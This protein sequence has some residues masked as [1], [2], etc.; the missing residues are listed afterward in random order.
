MSSTSIADPTESVGT[1]QLWVIDIYGFLLA[2]FLITMGHLGDRIGRR[3]LLLIG[4]AAFGLTSVAAA[5]STTA[6]SLIARRALMGVAAATLMPST[7]ALISNMFTD[8]RQR[9]W[10]IAGWATSQCAGAAFGPVV[11]GLLL[12]HFGWGSVFPLN[13]PIMAGLLVAGPLLRPE[14]RNPNP[15]R[16]DPTSVALS[17]VAVLLFVYG[18]KQVGTV[19][20]SGPAA[21]GIAAGAGG[22]IVFVRRQLARPSPGRSRATIQRW[23]RPRVPRTRKP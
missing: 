23:S 15:G 19:D 10:A 21:A 5:Y 4:G 22:G 18:L 20:F 13:V 11:T 7:L 17:L 6:G 8:D 3:R 14:F 12:E 9:G 2:G 16:L 1:E